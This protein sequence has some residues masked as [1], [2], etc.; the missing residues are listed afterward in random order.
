M[1][2]SA[3]IELRRSLSGKISDLIF[4][5]VIR[6]HSIR[7]YSL[8]FL[9]IEKLLEVTAWSTSLKATIFC[10]MG[11]GGEVMRSN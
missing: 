2:R 7:T 3:L 9:G 10:S 6:L 5:G 8:L 11:P 1:F 4:P